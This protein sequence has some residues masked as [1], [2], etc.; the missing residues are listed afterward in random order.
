[1]VFSIFCVDSIEALEARAD[2]YI[3]INQPGQAEADYSAVLALTPDNFG[4]VFGRAQARIM[5]Q[6]FTG[7]LEDIDRLLSYYPNEGAFYYLRAVSMSN[8]GKIDD[9][10]RELDRA[11]SQ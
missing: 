3:E 2:A 11:L 6:D 1:M 4:A 10:L 5:R 9:A 8:L 7:S